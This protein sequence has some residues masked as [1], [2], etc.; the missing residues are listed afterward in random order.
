M[1]ISVFIDKNRPEEVVVYAHE[2]TRLIEDI[3]QL[4]A[5]S[6]EALVGYKDRQMVPL[7][8]SDVCCFIVEDNK[9]Y[10]LTQGDKLQ[11]K[12]RLY[13]L[14]E[15][16]PDSFVKINKSCIANLKMIERFDAAFSGSLQV[17]F[18]NGYV[19]YV[20]RRNLKSVKERFGL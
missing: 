18:K 2:K 1:K 20:S 14:E 6:A 12:C 5:D 3:E 4:V 16:L 9:I 11:L 13:R 15:R 8:L 7:G 17:R 10:A 19:D